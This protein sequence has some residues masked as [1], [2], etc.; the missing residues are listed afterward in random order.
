MNRDPASLVAR[1][2]SGRA[3][4]GRYFPVRM[5]CAIGENT[6]W[7]TPSSIE[8]GTT[9]ASMTRHSAEYCGWL[10]TNGIF[11]SCAISQPARISVAVHSETPM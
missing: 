1:D 8:V 9:S 3:A 6:T 5:P 10:E 7:P 4:P 2:P 11:R